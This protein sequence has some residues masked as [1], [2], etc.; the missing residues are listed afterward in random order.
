MTRLEERYRQFHTRRRIEI[1]RLTA[2]RF[3]A[4]IAEGFSASGSNHKD[5]LFYAYDHMPSEEAQM[6]EFGLSIVRDC[7]SILEDDTDRHRREYFSRLLKV[8][9]GVLG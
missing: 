6:I 7:I 5:A 3:D 9:F 8:K 1:E 4:M 2:A